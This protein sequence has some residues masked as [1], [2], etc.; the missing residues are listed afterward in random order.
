[1]VLVTSSIYSSREIYLFGAD[2]LLHVIGPSHLVFRWYFKLFP[3]RAFLS[4]PCGASLYIIAMCRSFVN[5]FTLVSEWSTSRFE[6]E[7][8]HSLNYALYA[9]SVEDRFLWN[10]SEESLNFFLY[11]L[12][13]VSK[14]SFEVGVERALQKKK[15]PESHLNGGVKGTLIK[16]LVHIRLRSS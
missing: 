1:M 16:P 12:E 9:R 3:R 14:I 7:V 8:L 5:Y 13:N 11:F 10:F 15:H 4:F 6:N 2:S